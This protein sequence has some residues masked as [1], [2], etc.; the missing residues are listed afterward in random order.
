MQLKIILA[1][2]TGAISANT[3][4]KISYFPLQ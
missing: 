2:H 3:P 4:S 1:R